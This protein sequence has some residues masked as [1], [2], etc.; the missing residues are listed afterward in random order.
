MTGAHAALLLGLIA[1]LLDDLGLLILKRR[2]DR[3]PPLTFPFPPRILLAY[4]RDVPWLVGLFLQPVGYAVYLV[5]LT[6][7]PL[8]VVQPAA[9]ADV[10]LFVPIAVLWFGERL[11]KLEWIGTGAVGGG[12]IL[13]S[14]T[15]T[16]SEAGPGVQAGAV[17]LAGV[18][19]GALILS[20][21][22]ALFWRRYPEV[23]LG[24]TSGVILGLASVYTK[25]FV[26]ALAG[27]QAGGAGA[28]LGWITLGLLALAAN[29]VGFVLLLVGFQRGR[30]SVVFTVNSGF[31]NGFPILAGVVAFGEALPAG[32]LFGGLRIV[33]LVLTLGGAMALTRF[34]MTDTFAPRAGSPRVSGC[35]DP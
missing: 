5:A 25:A 28:A 7:G 26:Q 13:L 1:A 3:L 33:S 14:L 16:Q 2:G 23:M 12:V 32:P 11:T 20:G 31:S 9:A 18:S 6:R 35:S 22:A 34:A 10:I 15:L 27:A 8:G 30:G 19:A 29:L 4:F 24:A 17:A 21:A